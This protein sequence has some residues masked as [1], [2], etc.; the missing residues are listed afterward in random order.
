MWRPYWPP[1]VLEQSEKVESRGLHYFYSEVHL[2]SA[3]VY[4]IQKS[5]QYDFISLC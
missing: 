5:I 1:S 4:R 2:R 3:T